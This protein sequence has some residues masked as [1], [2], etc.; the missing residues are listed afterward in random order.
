MD[1]ED[2]AKRML[3]FLR[4]YAQ[5]FLNS[6]LMDE[7]RSL[8]PALVSDF[9]EVGLLGL[10]IPRSLQGQELSHSDTHRVFTQLGAIDANLA[11]LCV[12]QNTLGTPPIVLAANDAVKQHVLPRIATGQALT[13]IAI[14]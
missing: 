3:G 5:N 7:R 2:S 6:R 4:E 9:A 13:T 12:V 14:S 8:P 1:T 11:L 10:Q